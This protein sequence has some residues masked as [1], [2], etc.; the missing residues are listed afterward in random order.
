MMVI[1]VMVIMMERRTRC[2]MMTER[3]NEV[4]AIGGDNDGD[5]EGY[6]Q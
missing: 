6:R 1:T 2:I 5:G 3:R 4:V